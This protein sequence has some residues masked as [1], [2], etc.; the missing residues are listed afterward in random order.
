MFKSPRQQGFTMIELI[1]V[2][3]IFG[4]WATNAI[5]V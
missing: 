1:I 2:V 4:I 5:P 3:A